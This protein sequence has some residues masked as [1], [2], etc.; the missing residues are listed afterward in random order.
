M[1]LKDWNNGFR[2]IK[3]EAVK[4]LELKADRMEHASEIVEQIGKQNITYKE[5]P[6]TITY[7]EE[8]LQ[9]GQS[10]FAAVGILW[11]MVKSKVLK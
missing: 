1:R 10:T 9:K 6:V 8:S 7:T 5:I 2:A 3:R 4:K 11:N